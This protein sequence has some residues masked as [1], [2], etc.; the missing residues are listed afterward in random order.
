MKKFAGF[1]LLLA[2]GQSDLD[3]HNASV[4]NTHI[5]FVVTC[6]YRQGLSHIKYPE[7]IADY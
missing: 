6:C 3:K 5:L 2:T 4:T 1:Y 7:L